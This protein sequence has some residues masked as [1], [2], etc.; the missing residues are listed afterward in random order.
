MVVAEVD[1]IRMGS[2]EFR[3]K[4]PRKLLCP[5]LPAEQGPLFWQ[6][7]IGKVGL[8]EWLTRIIPRAD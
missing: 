8:E 1:D 6:N 7:S 5:F 3:S 4:R 2:C